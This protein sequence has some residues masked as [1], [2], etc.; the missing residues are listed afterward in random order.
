MGAG[1]E[2]QRVWMACQLDWIMAAWSLC[3]RRCQSS[4]MAALE[5]PA[6]TSR[7]AWRVKIWRSQRSEGG[8]PKAE[9]WVQ[10][11]GMKVRLRAWQ[12]GPCLWVLSSARCVRRALMDVRACFVYEGRKAT[13][14][15]ASAEMAGG[16][17]EGERATRSVQVAL[18]EEEEFSRTR[19]GDR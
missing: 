1:V 17:W 7:R 10:Q 8:G 19:Y 12:P 18:V 5:R 2:M 13:E 9:W 14:T 15:V 11:R 4:A 3:Q 16:V 6:V